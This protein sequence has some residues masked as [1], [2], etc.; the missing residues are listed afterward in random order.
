MIYNNQ[1]YSIFNINLNDLTNKDN[2]KIYNLGLYNFFK[3]ISNCLNTLNYN[4]DN[5]N[6]NDFDVLMFD[7]KNFLNKEYFL[8]PKNKSY[9]FDYYFDKINNFSSYYLNPISLKSINFNINISFFNNI[10]SLSNEFNFIKYFFTDFFDFFFND[11]D[12][13][14]YDDC[15][16]DLLFLFDDLCDNIKKTYFNNNSLSKPIKIN[17]HKHISKLFEEN[18]INCSFS[19]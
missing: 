9:N 6:I 17:K 16:D 11:I 5:I 15:I 14:N 18:N 1:K 19:Y 13:I 12:I 8:L 4:L 7:Y 2:D 3:L 10:I